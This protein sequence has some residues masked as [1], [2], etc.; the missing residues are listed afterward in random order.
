MYMKINALIFLTINWRCFFCPF[1]KRQGGFDRQ[2]QKSL[3]LCPSSGEQSLCVKFD[4][5]K[6]IYKYNIYKKNVLYIYHLFI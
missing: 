2:M 5:N 6:K 1:N 4:L 3:A